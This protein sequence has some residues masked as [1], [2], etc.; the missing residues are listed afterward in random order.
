MPLQTIFPEGTLAGQL[1][2]KKAWP[3]GDSASVETW[4]P[5]LN[6]IA[7]IWF[8][9][10]LTFGGT[11]LRKHKSQFWKIDT[12]RLFTS[13]RSAPFRWV[14]ICPQPY[15]CTENFG[16]WHVDCTWARFP[17]ITAFFVELVC[18]C[19][20][21]TLSCCQNKGR[22]GLNGWRFERHSMLSVA[23]QK[24]IYSSEISDAA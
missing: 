18:N 22:R 4:I 8:P 7:F 12:G 17:C 21:T 13:P 19:T 20:W 23:S 11:R 5:I 10:F 15:K 9:T 1:P 2:L 14:V 6:R 3:K 16:S 24:S